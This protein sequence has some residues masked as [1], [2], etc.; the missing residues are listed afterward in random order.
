MSSVPRAPS[1]SATSSSRELVSAQSV[2]YGPSH[3]LERFIT[4]RQPNLVPASLGRD[5]T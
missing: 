4:V 1:H 5:D 3:V 2:I